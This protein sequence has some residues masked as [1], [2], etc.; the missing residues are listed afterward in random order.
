MKPEELLV[1]RVSNYLLEN[2]PKVPFRFD[3]GA[4]VKLPI[5]VARKLHALHGKWS[6]GYPDLFVCV[7]KG[8]FGGLYVELKAT[9]EVPDTEH[10]RRQAE[11]HAVLR[12]NGYKVVFA[13]GYKEATKVI[14][15]YL[16]GK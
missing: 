9:D 13:C 1:K 8:G 2:H 4:D 3:T 5:G 16:K 12:H 11:Y 14:K 15:K 10:T 7:C 6:R